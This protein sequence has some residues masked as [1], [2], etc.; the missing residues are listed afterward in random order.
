MEDLFAQASLCFLCDRCDEGFQQIRSSL[1]ERRSPLD[2]EEQSVFCLLSMRVIEQRYRSWI[3]LHR[4]LIDT[5]Q[6][7]ERRAIGSYIDVILDELYCQANEVLRLIDRL[8]VD[9]PP[10]SESLLFYLKAQGD[11]HRL[12]CQTCRGEKQMEHF[13]L[14]RTSYNRVLQ[15]CD[16]QRSTTS[17]S[18][19]L[20]VV[21]NKALVGR[22]CCRPSL[23]IGCI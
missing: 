15:L 5:N 8:L 13:L 3:L 14:A 12:I 9:T 7:D 1:S 19:A 11:I 22:R 2:A 17:H 21:S 20:S 6:L 18:I 16:E 23:C 10:S 4:Q